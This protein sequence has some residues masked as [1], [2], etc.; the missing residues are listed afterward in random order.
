MALTDYELTPAARRTLNIFLMIDVSGSMAGEKI[1]AVNDA[2]RNVIPIINNIGESNP[3]AEIKIS[4]MTFS[5]SVDWLTPQPVTAS[6]MT[7][8]D[9]SASGMTCLG[10][11][12]KELNRQL[13]HKTG[14]LKS[15]SGSY[16]PVVILLS[17][18]GPTDDFT[19]G[20]NALSGNAWFRHST[21]IAIAIGNDADT[22]V[23]ATFTGNPELVF[24]VHNIDALKTVIR[25]AVVTSSMVCS[26]SSSVSCG[27][28][29]SAAHGSARA[30][31]A[32]LPTGSTG[33]APSKSQLTADA[34][35]MELEGEIGIDVGDDALM[36]ELDID[37][38]D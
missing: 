1:A 19:A 28:M 20:M 6:G 33:L 8:S 11:A 34:I 26:Q 5:S 18:G 32:G 29:A 38:F 35:A 30:S 24:R 3:D 27:G 22:N 14:F 7:W 37:E 2:V 36:N 15:A 4:A 12:C 31:N 21:R 25:V 13:S 10:E 23:L 9:Q 17:D 16:A